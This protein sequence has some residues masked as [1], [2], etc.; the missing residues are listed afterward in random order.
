MSLI[1]TKAQ[2]L[3]LLFV[4]FLIEYFKRDLTVCS[5]EFHFFHTIMTVEKT[6]SHVAW[7]TAYNMTT[8]AL[9]RL[10]GICTSEITCALRS[11]KD[12]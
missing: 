3:S 7:I 1:Q 2:H 5:P 8:T 10:R 6:Q 12:H 4:A 11:G 9:T